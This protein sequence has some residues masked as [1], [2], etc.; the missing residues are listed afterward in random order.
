MEDRDDKQI[1]TEN[2][3]VLDKAEKTDQGEA[4]SKGID[5][6][7][8]FI[9]KNMFYVMLLSLIVAVLVCIILI[10]QNHSIRN[11]YNDQLTL[12]ERLM[13]ENQ[14]LTVKIEENSS[15]NEPNTGKDEEL[16]QAKEDNS[17]LEAELAEVNEK[18]NNAL[19]ENEL[20]KQQDNTSALQEELN[21]LNEK[22]KESLANEEKLK[23]IYTKLLDFVNT[24][25][26]GTEEYHS[27]QYIIFTDGKEKEIT[28]T[29]R[30][31]R[32]YTTTVE[33]DNYGVLTEWVSPFENYQARLKIVP[34]NEGVTKFHFT[35]S[36]NSDSFDV[37]VVYLKSK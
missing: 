28:V 24:D 35:N 3:P 9:H 30:S 11:K 4:E 31:A 8:K 17:K 15:V 34:K 27:D 26:L 10:I 5:R 14:D 20:L 33:G 23:E 32:K 6:H 22:L 25:Y 36:F 7:G 21:D 12:N 29:A 16:N 13:S 37:L 1:D 2:I 18:L 19:A